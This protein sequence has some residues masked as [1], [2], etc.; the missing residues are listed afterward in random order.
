[1]PY[2]INDLKFANAIVDSF[3]EI[4]TEFKGNGSHA[5]HESTR[6]TQSKTSAIEINCQNTMPISYSLSNFPDAKPGFFS[7]SFLLLKFVY[8]KSFSFLLI[9]F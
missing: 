4:S 6:G 7:P 5:T 9:F 8:K 3:L 2:H 1:M